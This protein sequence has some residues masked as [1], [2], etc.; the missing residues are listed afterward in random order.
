MSVNDPKQ[1]FAD[2]L[3]L[4]DP[5]ARRLRLPFEYCDPLAQL[6]G[7]ELRIHGGGKAGKA[8]KHRTFI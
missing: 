5:L 2:Y 6:D 1:T 4:S 3:V 8:G 7:F